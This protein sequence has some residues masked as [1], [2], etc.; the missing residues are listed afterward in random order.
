[1]LG[2][3]VSICIMMC[4]AMYGFQKYTIM[5]QFGDTNFQQNTQFGTIDKLQDFSESETQ[6]MTS[7]TIYDIATNQPRSLESLEGYFEVNARYWDNQLVSMTPTP[8][9]TRKCTQDDFDK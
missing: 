3:I 4:V 2:A 8:V 6:L 5:Q 7:F 1:M 9:K